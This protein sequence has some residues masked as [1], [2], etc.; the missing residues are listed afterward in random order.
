MSD[1]PHEQVYHVYCDESR[2]SEHRYCE[3]DHARRLV[4]HL[5]HRNSSYSLDTLKAVLN[6]GM[7]KKF[8]HPAQPFVAVEPRDSKTTD[9]IQIADLLLGAVGFQKNGLHLLAGSKAAKIE[10]AAYIAEKAGMD[11]L[12]WDTPR[13]N[14]R[15]TIWNF[16]LRPKN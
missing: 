10:L 7:K 1:T 9:L 4:V 8:Q 15:F 12:T 6:R 14:H 5:D 3:K 16:R 11:D 13:R 2:Q